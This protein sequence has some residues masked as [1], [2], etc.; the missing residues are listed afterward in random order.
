MASIG[1]N[2]FFQQQLSLDEWDEVIP[3][4]VIEQH[5]SRVALATES[6]HIS[7]QLTPN[8]PT[9]V[10]GD[11]L[12]L[13]KKHRFYRLLERKTCFRR[14]SAGADVNW[15]LIAANVDTAF[16]V[17]SLNDDFNLNRIERY[18]SLANAAEVEPV[19]VLSKSDLVDEP[20][21]WLEQV[22]Q[23]DK[24]LPVVTI[25]ALSPGCSDVLN[26]WLSV[27][28]TVVIL[29][30][31][32][33]G[34]STITN[35]LLGEQRQATGGIREDDDKGRH[36]T[37]NRSLISLPGGAMIL[38]TP[39]M[40]ELQIAHC[41]DGIASTFADIEELSLQCRFSDCSHDTEP[42]CAVVA[43]VS[44]GKLDARRRKNYQ[45]LIKEEAMNSASL[46]ERRA[47]DKALGKFYKRTL[48][49]AY[50]IK[51]RQ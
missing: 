47:N 22:H 29:G 12:L 46:S 27:G 20:Q 31:S 25:N 38:D 35:T 18:L 14:K 36:T 21:M 45:K 40:R 17:C 3:A 30:S 8:M 37:T 7:L 26:E 6:G 34:K 5:K 16:I 28:K 33:V 23:M 43:A 44:A 9:L 32:G 49:D 42:G 4:R 11:W 15:Q 2:P 39:G 48:A 1:W 19:I 50:K 51:G 13:D 24:N 41:Q 10:E